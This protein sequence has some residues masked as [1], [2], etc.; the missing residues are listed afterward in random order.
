MSGAE[1]QEILKRLDKLDQ[2][3]SELFNRDD[4]QDRQIASNREAVRSIQERWSKHAHWTDDEKEG[5]LIML[6]TLP[7]T[8]RKVIKEE[9]I[10]ASIKADAQRYRDLRR[11]GIALIAG[12]ITSGAVIAPVLQWL[13]ERLGG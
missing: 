2:H 4:A 6:K 8:I 5:A 3:I 12:V 10:E 7:T 1:A 11:W 9:T 13:I